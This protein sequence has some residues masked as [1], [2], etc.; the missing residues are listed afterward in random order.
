MHS[1][2]YYRDSVCAGDDYVNCGQLIKMADDA[3]LEDLVQFI[4]HTH[5]GHY[6]FIPYTGGRAFW[7]LESDA[8]RLAVVCDDGKQV[9]Y[10]S[11]KP[12]TSLTDIGITNIM[13]KHL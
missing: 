2:K 4:M 1:I 3:T 6:S 12:T 5:Y 7:A 11:Y 10:S 13:G 8:G 9:T